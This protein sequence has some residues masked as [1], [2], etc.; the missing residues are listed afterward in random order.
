[1]PAW[2]K[3]PFCVLCGVL[4]IWILVQMKRVSESLQPAD[5]APENAVQCDAVVTEV[6]RHSTRNGRSTGREFRI[7]YTFEGEEY[8]ESIYAGMALPSVKEGDTLHLTVD[9]T[10]PHYATIDVKEASSAADTLFFLRIG[11]FGALPVLIVAFLA[12]KY[13]EKG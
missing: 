10:N 12:K 1:M 3:I 6:I 5:I 8:N 13:K 11:I 2:M 7:S 4:I 9:K